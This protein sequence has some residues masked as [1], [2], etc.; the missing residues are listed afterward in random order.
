MTAASDLTT[1]CFAWHFNFGLLPCSTASCCF[2]SGFGVSPKNYATCA[3]IDG[4][5][6]ECCNANYYHRDGRCILCDTQPGFSCGGQ[7]GAKLTTLSLNHGWWRT[8]LT[9]LD[10]YE[11]PNRNACSGGPAA[12]TG[13]V[14]DYCAA[15][16]TGPCELTQTVVK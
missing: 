2:A 4:V 9:S 10:A 8:G 14:Q 11:C 7:I 1:V 3:D 12:R 6:G 16:Y 15:G 5:A 13:T